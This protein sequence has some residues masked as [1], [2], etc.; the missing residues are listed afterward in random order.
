[1]A[2]GGEVCAPLPEDCENGLDDD[3]D[4]L[5]DDLDPKPCSRHHG[6]RAPCTQDFECGQTGTCLLIDYGYPNGYCSI[7][8][9]DECPGDGVCERIWGNNYACFDGCE[10]RDDCRAGYDCMETETGNFACSPSCTVLGC[11]AGETC[12]FTTGACTHDGPSTPGGPCV[13]SNE[14]SDNGFCLS[15]ND[16]GFL[17]GFCALTCRQK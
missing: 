10:T 15:E 8:C 4:G 5:A 3:C 6:G 9:E 13:Q 16:Y 2:T 14:C 12:D 7:G 1:M 17:G 11:P